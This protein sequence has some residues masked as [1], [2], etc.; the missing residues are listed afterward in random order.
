MYDFF[1]SFGIRRIARGSQGEGRELC[2]DQTD[3][4]SGLCKMLHLEGP[5]GTAWVVSSETGR[6]VIIDLISCT[7]K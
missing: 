7:E 6:V 4:D 1:C 5:T 2:L 3:S